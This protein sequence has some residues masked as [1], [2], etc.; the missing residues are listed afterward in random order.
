MKKILL[1]VPILFLTGCVSVE[2]PGDNDCYRYIDYAG[3][4]N[5]MDWHSNLCQ[6]EGAELFCR[7]DGK[8][9]KVSEYE[10]V[11]CPKEE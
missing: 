1:I 2:V 9:F 7:E 5:Y 4:E 6:T 11:E 8:V 10:R 3:S